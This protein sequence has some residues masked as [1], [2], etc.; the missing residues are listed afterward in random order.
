R[1]RA[2]HLGQEAAEDVP[3]GVAE[4]RDRGPG[5][6]GRR[7]FV[8]GGG[9]EP[10]VVEER[11]LRVVVGV[12][13]H[14]RGQAPAFARMGAGRLLVHALEV[15]V[16]AEAARPDR[17]RGAPAAVEALEAGAIVTEPLLREVGG[18]ARVEA[19]PGE[20]EGGQAA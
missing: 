14:E 10:P 9:A 15:Q 6:A 5:G 16:E 17:A 1:D 19:A 7:S 18:N 3:A 12:E 20:G 4:G 11:A 13:R 8:A 2:R